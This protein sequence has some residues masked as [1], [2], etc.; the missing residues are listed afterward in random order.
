MG[1]IITALAVIGVLWLVAKKTAPAL[2]QAP[3]LGAY[4]KLR[5]KGLSAEDAIVSAV[6]T[7]TYRAPFDQL[8]EADIRAFA[9]VFTRC[10]KPELFT[11]VLFEAQKAGQAAL[12]QDLPTLED[13]VEHYNAQA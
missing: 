7:L 11:N 5:E 9:R 8:S 10:K 13:F 6:S 3:W 4:R 12:I 1:T 2:G